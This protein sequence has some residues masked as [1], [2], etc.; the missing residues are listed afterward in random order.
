MGEIR[1]KCPE[2]G[3]EYRL[4]ADAIP[5]RGRDVECSA[6]GNVWHGTR[7]AP[8]A[9]VA[10]PADGAGKS[11]AGSDPAPRLNRPLPDNVLAILREEATREMDARSAE[12]PPTPAAIRRHMPGLAGAAIPAAG[13]RV[14]AV[15]DWP[16]TTVVVTAPPG[17]T[18]HAPATDAATVPVSAPL[19]LPAGVPPTPAPKQTAKPT[20]SA[21]AAALPDARVSQQHRLGFRLGLGLSVLFLALYLAAPRMADSGALGSAMTEMR[22]SVDAGRLWL[23]GLLGGGGQQP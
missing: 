17:D 19:P 10:D 16:A 13:P 2:C 9:P 18:A 14:S 22:Q 5:V 6:C 23:S 3:A 15:D 11:A 20:V 21:S 12:A 7:P 8:A 4:P 1:L